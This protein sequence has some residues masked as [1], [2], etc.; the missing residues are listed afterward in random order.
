MWLRFAE[1]IGVDRE[2]VRSAERTHATD[3]L[4]QTYRDLTGR[5]S[6]AAGVAAV[7]AYERQVPEVSTSKI[8]GLRRHYAIEDARTLEFFKVHGVLD[9]EHSGAERDM[10]E[11]LSDGDENEAL[12]ATSAALDAWWAFLTAVDRAPVAVP[13]A[14]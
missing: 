12:A 6:L 14:S 13:A 11:Q 9:V 3:R 8:D 2:D 10:I 1:G 4:L 5:A 7:Y